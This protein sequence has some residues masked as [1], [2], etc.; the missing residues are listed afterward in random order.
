LS[1]IGSSSSYFIGDSSLII[2][3]FS[4]QNHIIFTYFL[5][6]YTFFILLPNIK[7]TIN[8]L[9]PFFIINLLADEITKKGM[10]NFIVNNSSNLENLELKYPFLAIFDIIRVSINSDDSETSIYGIE[11]ITNKIVNIIEEENVQEESLKISKYFIENM[12]VVLQLALEK[13]SEQ[14]VSQIIKS[15]GMLAKTSQKRDMKKIRAYSVQSLKK[16]GVGIIQSKMD[17]AILNLSLIF[18][19]IGEL[20]YGH[21]NYMIDEC[22]YAV[23]QIVKL[24]IDNKLFSVVID[25]TELLKTS[26]LQNSIEFDIEKVKGG[27]RIGNQKFLISDPL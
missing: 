16:M 12:L 18:V 10:L 4:L 15:I 1:Q 14:S 24:A 7:N 6:S 17:Q 22:A 5:G 2:E 21:D 20:S 3:L 11:T 26:S 8:F 27:Y 23:K 9:D 13:N 19:E 25:I